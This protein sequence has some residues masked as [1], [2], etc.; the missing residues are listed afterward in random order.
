MWT[1]QCPRTSSV[2]VPPYLLEQSG[3]RHAQPGILLQAGK[4]SGF[5]RAQTD[6]FLRLIGCGG[7]ETTHR[8]LH[9]I[10]STLTVS[11]LLPSAR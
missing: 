6:C 1:V 7:L 9:G 4:Q 2:A 10:Y 3:S 5:D 11:R 8:S